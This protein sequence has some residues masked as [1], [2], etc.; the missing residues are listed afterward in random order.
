LCR[1]SF[2]RHG[3]YICL[4]ERVYKISGSKPSEARARRMKL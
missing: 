4:S 3:V 2:Y 1:A